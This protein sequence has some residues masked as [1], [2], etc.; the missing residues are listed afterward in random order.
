[1][2]GG[3]S[4]VELDPNSPIKS[5]ASFLQELVLLGRATI[6]GSPS[7]SASSGR[8]PPSEGRRRAGA[9]LRRRR[10]RDAGVSSPVAVPP[11]APLA[12]GGGARRAA[13]ASPRSPRRSAR[14][15]SSSAGGR[16]ARRRTRRR[17]RADG[18]H[19][20]QE[21]R[22][23][24]AARAARETEFERVV[25]GHRSVV[26]LIV[27]CGHHLHCARLRH[28]QNLSTPSPTCPA[29]GEERAPSTTPRRP[30]TRART[31]EARVAQRRRRRAAPRAAA[32]PRCRRADGSAPR[33]RPPRGPPLLAVLLLRPRRLG[34]LLPPARHRLLGVVG[35][36]VGHPLAEVSR[37]HLGA[38]ARALRR[39]PA[40]P[41]RRLLRRRLLR[42][43]RLRRR[44]PS[45]RRGAAASP[46]RRAAAATS[47]AAARRRARRWRRARR[48]WRRARRVGLASVHLPRARQTPP[49]PQSG[50]S[51]SDRPAA[52]RSTYGARGRR[53]RPDV[54]LARTPPS[55][56]SRPTC[57]RRAAG[58]LRR[59]GGSGTTC[60]CTAPTVPPST[61]RPA[62]A[63]TTATARA[64]RV[65]E[66]AGL[67]VAAAAAPPFS[68]NRTRTRARS[69]PES[70][71]AR[72]ASGCPRSAAQRGTPCGVAA[73]KLQ[74]PPPRTRARRG[75]RRR[76]SSTG[77]RP[78]SRTL[79]R[80]SPRRP[81]LQV[82]Q[83]A[84]VLHPLVARPEPPPRQP[85]SPGSSIA[86]SV[87]PWQ[88]AAESHTRLAIATDIALQQ[89][90]AERSVAP[91][92][93][94][95]HGGR[96]RRRRGVSRRRR[97]RC[98][99]GQGRGAARCSACSQSPK[100]CKNLLTKNPSPITDRAAL[101]ARP[102]PHQLAPQPAPSKFSPVEAIP[103]S[104]I[105]KIEPLHGASLRRR[106]SAR[107]LHF[108]SSQRLACDGRVGQRAAEGVEVRALAGDAARSNSSSCRT[109]RAG[110]NRVE[111]AAV[112]G[113]QEDWEWE[114]A[115]HV[116]AELDVLR[117]WVGE[118]RLGCERRHWAWELQ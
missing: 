36:G 73:G 23:G 81:L 93:G 35:V 19:A 6:K 33:A 46:A 13:P 39:P 114:W 67:A 5:I 79:R 82:R 75:S 59:R 66:R 32:R 37:E 9:R 60:D 88:S 14:R 92:G 8:S 68:E 62:A 31:R 30:G 4:N 84:G 41:R 85:H 10:L 3:F 53:E 99:L 2:P 77:R 105:T 38:T 61:A 111:W 69:P 91:V 83:V 27:V 12:A 40:P 89:V 87:K 24:V 117:R 18:G 100:A 78:P 52:A 70:P 7:A 15:G 95:R 44:R 48:R 86:E 118:Q 16:R 49:A 11:A 71:R 98:A 113:W 104:P 80:A 56:P 65:H 28:T 97:R 116:D 22:V 108:T 43:R 96:H 1:M 76:R 103:A 106:L 58:S 29:A 74:E 101:R 94:V 102:A 50:G 45:A 63:A 55:P 20:R 112:V 57:W 72:L 17:R 115:G 47:I 107:D 64:A 51:R 109:R 54:R 26:V 34:L 21:G 42:R 110:A 90:G 25:S